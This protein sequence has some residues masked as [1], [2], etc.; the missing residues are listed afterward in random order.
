MS[1]KSSV[2]GDPRLAVITVTRDNPTELLLTCRSVSSQATPPGAHI[3]IDGSR[4]LF[5]KDNFRIATENGAKYVWQEPNGIYD[6]MRAGLALLDKADYVW[7]LNATDRLASSKAVKNV[8][9]AIKESHRSQNSV[10]FIGK[11]MVERPVPY[12][13][14]WSLSGLD[15]AHW[16]QKGRVGV[17]HSSMIIQVGVM[18]QLGAFGGKP[19]ISKDYELALKVL[20]FHGPPTMIPAVLS[21]YD[22]SGVSSRR[23]LETYVQKAQ[24]R[25]RT[26]SILSVPQESVRFVFAIGRAFAKKLIPIFP[27]IRWLWKIVGWNQVTNADLRASRWLY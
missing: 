24:A 16:L 9:D 1:K 3:V 4:E 5:R 23:A 20:D 19:G 21:V 11:T 7:F 18:K 15:F 13:L 14:P 8:L 12:T 10:W 25:I 17:P 6:A 27:Q 26:N 22:I 2:A